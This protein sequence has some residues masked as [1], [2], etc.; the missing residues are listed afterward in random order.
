M[1]RVHTAAL[2]Y[3]VF[4]SATMSDS[5]MWI[6][7]ISPFFT[8]SVTTLVRRSSHTDFLGAVSELAQKTV[9]KESK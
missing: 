8:C 5:S 2:M 6:G 4:E 7:W 3:L 9:E 1:W